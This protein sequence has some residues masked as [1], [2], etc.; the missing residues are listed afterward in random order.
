MLP[1]FPSEAMLHYIAVGNITSSSK[2][3]I[4][5]H[6]FLKVIFNLDSVI[7]VGTHSPIEGRVCVRYKPCRRAKFVLLC[8][9]SQT[10]VNCIIVDVVQP[11]IIARLMGEAGVPELKPYLV[12]RHA[13][14]SV[15][16]PRRSRM[17]TL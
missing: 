14:Q 8:N 7:F 10:M 16:R 11:R 17:K 6:T 4:R 13:I 3:T 15:D 9:R 2:S 5:A 1:L 12:S